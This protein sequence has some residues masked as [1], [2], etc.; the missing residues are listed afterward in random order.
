MTHYHEMLSMML[1][2]P[3]SRELEIPQLYALCT[4]CQ[5]EQHSKPPPALD[6]MMARL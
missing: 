3:G 4:R 2:Y 1:Q 5:G 6:P